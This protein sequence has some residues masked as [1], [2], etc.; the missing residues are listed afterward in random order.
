MTHVIVI[1]Y[2]GQHD[3]EPTTRVYGS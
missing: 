3:V 1:S 2:I